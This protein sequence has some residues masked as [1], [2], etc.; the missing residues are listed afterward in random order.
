M[1]RSNE[2]RGIPE[3]RPDEIASKPL[4]FSFKHLD[5]T[6]QKFAVT[7]CDVGFLRSLL[8]ALRKFS[9]WV[10]GDFVDQ[11][12]NE[13]RHII[14]FA[15]TS[16]TD[17]FVRAPKINEDQLWQHDPWQFGI[18]TD[19]PSSRWRI[20]GILIDDTFFIVWLDPKHA[21]FPDPN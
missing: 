15:A 1:P 16:E 9:D 19:D 7:N 20:H 11:N 2:G 6:H 21:L 5:T 14:D 13:H 18:P 8:A 10:V 4:R 3:P 17:G 12:N